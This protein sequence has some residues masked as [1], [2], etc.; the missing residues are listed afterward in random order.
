MDRPEAADWP[1]RQRASGFGSYRSQLSFHRFAGSLYV[2][3]HTFF[4]FLHLFKHSP[5]GRLHILHTHI[6]RHIQV[7][8]KL[9]NNQCPFF[10]GKN[11]F[12]QEISHWAIG[13]RRIACAIIISLIER[14]KPTVF[15]CKT[16]AELDAGIIH[17]LL[18]ELIFQFKGDDR[19][20]IDE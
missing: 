12:L 16:S 19:Q 13:I 6:D 11:I 18:C 7:T 9:L 2:P 5:L 1:P 8:F 20:S 15:A 17:I 4:Y 14:Q 10:F 3:L